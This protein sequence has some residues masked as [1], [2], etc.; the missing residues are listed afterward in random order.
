LSGQAKECIDAN[1]EYSD[2]YALLRRFHSFSVQR[3]AQLDLVRFNNV[4]KSLIAQ[5]EANPTSE[6]GVSGRVLKRSLNNIASDLQDWLFYY[7][8]RLKIHKVVDDFDSV[9]GRA[10]RTGAHHGVD[11]VRQVQNL[12]LTT[13]DLQW[14]TNVYQEFFRT[15]NEQ[16]CRCSARSTSIEF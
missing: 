15:Q 8:E 4:I 7:M 6:L 1:D 12:D 10:L 14:R 16:P 2:I 9:F 5:I 3:N 11:Y 13:A